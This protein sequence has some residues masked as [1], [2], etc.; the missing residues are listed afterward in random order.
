MEKLENIK[1]IN[2][3]STSLKHDGYMVVGFGVDS[4]TT[5][6]IYVSFN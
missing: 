5:Q 3:Y 2:T 4:T 6:I 1:V